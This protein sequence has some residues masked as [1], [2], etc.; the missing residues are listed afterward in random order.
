MSQEWRSETSSFSR[1][2]FLISGKEFNIRPGR[3]LNGSTLCMTAG[4]SLTS[5]VVQACVCLDSSGGMLHYLSYWLQNSVFTPYA[6]CEFLCTT[7]KVLFAFKSPRTT[8]LSVTNDVLHCQVI[9]IV[10]SIA[11]FWIN[12]LTMNNSMTH[13]LCIKSPNTCNESHCLISIFHSS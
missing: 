5:S 11:S 4:M 6:A 2:V 3:C 12:K 8:L 1:G 10:F 9:C 13:L 7:V